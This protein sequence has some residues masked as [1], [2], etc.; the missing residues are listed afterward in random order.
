MSGDKQAL[1]RHHT[2][3]GA[4][5]LG[6]SLT[7]TG[8]TIS[9][10][11]DPGKVTPT[12]P[13]PSEATP[14][15]PTGFTNDM[16]ITQA[17]AL[18]DKLG[19]DVIDTVAEPQAEDFTQALIAAGALTDSTEQGSNTTT[20]GSTSDAIFWALKISDQCVIGQYHPLEQD[21]NK[22]HYFSTT[23]HPINEQC[24]IGTTSG[25]P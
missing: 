7:L 20:Q 6:V 23:S 5:M 24:L 1:H 9:A 15:A 19:T 12:A 16:D 17:K 4:L 18:F 10:A 21:Q 25:R 3:A 8:C 13:A 22:L 11:D 2:P 14:T